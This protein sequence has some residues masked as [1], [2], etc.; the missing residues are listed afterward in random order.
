MKIYYLLTIDSLNGTNI[1]T[2]KE[3]LN[4]AIDWAQ[5]I[6][7]VYILESTSNVEKWLKRLKPILGD[8][9]FFLIKVDLNNRTGWLSKQAWE[10]IG[11]RE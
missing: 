2:F 3:K 11:K 10:W 5:I 1:N 6:P 4:F 8:N 9:S 7:N